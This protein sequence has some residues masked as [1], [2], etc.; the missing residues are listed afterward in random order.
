[1]AAKPSDARTTIDSLAELLRER[2][3]MELSKVAQILGV[4]QNV[5]EN[6]AKVL[7]AGN[8]VKISYEVGKMY[9]EPLQVT[10]EQET[11]VAA[12]IDAQ[13][14]KLENDLA[15]QRTSLD[16]YSSKLDAISISVKSAETMF[17]QKF[18]EIETQLEGINKIYSALE[19]ENQKIETIR[20][21]AESTYEDVNK[22][23][24]V[25]SGK[26]EG[27]DSAT[28]ESSRDEMQKI[29]DV[30]KKAAEMENQL[31][32]LSKSKDRALE[33]IKKGIE[34]QLKVLEKDLDKAEQ[35]IS[36]QLKLDEDQIRKSL[37]T[38]RGE[39]RS[40]EEYSKQ[41]SSFRRDKESIRRSLKNTRESFNDEY[42]KISTRMDNVG[43]SLKNRIK[44]M[45]AELD[46]LKNNF[47]EID[48][49]YDTL[50]KSRGD[51]D[52]L[53][54]KIQQ[55]RKEIDDASE[56]VKALQTLKGSIETKSTATQKVADKVGGIGLE[57]A[58]MDTTMEKIT[59]DLED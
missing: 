10:K 59:K 25:L 38:M 27:E 52:A 21:H 28:L 36:Q 55:I 2:G 40:I 22:K 19:D 34:D 50:Q 6:W 15:L 5:V 11:A 39:A 53:Q 37:K 18:P 7:E 8:M 31:T 54:T 24:S 26:V 13:R 14:S 41:I 44:E 51:L 45:L 58:S 23:V 43:V 3:K 49:L 33:T 47:G 1:M 57:M 32:L 29:Q 46:T 42:T 20:K 17:R 48:K 9:V 56:E 16:R 35:S 4:E 12:I 30:L